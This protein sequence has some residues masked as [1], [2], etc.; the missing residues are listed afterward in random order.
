[1]ET[2][3]PLQREVEDIECLRTVFEQRIVGW[4]KD[5]ESGQAGRS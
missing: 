5:D 1:M 2:A 3:A 4:E